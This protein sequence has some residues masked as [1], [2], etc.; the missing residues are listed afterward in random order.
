MNKEF[1]NILSLLA[2]ALTFTLL[3]CS[4]SDDFVQTTTNISEADQIAGD[5]N[6]ITMPLVVPDDSWR[7]N[8]MPV[9]KSS[10]NYDYRTGQAAFSWTI[11]DE[12]IVFPVKYVEND[13]VKTHEAESS[14]SQVWEIKAVKQSGTQSIGVFEGED[15]AV[16][17]HFNESYIAVYPNIRYDR[18]YTNIPITYEGQKQKES[19][20]IKCYLDGIGY[21]TTPDA[22]RL[23]QYV[24]SE[25]A[26]C[27]NLSKFD[28]LVDKE[29]AATDV[30][31]MM[32]FNMTRLGSVVRFFMKV[33]DKVVFDSLQLY[34]DSKNFVHTTTLNGATGEYAAIPTKESHVTSL[35]L[36]DFG[37]DYYKS[38]ENDDYY[39]GSG[40]GWVMTA[41]MMIAPIDL[42]A[43]ETKNST[44]YLIG[45]EPLYYT[46]VTDYN[47][48]H[49]GGVIDEAAFNALTAEQKIKLYTNRDDYNTDNNKNLT[50]EQFAALADDARMMV[51]ADVDAF[52]AAKGTS[53]T[54]EQ[55]AVLTPAQ[56]M[57]RYTRKY[58]KATNLAKYNITAGGLYQWTIVGLNPDQPI[59]F[60]EI[61]IQE[62]KEG[63]NYTNTDGAGT[64]DW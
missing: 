24:V 29:R 4:D 48:D 27:E 31:G 49:S 42:S 56:K 32:H 26:A 13:E 35:Q 47:N 12:V 14:T 43:A 11:G 46:N 51:Y 57:T 5:K 21:N 18:N 3:S 45:R 1:R 38:A 63:V 33:P 39:Y 60:E 44:L 64:G 53:L 52:N 54:A 9:P 19:P 20:K 37:F 16:T 15:E 62:W 28:Y 40:I 10:L 55:F 17:A 50:A 2:L 22:N 59:T 30:A 61:T 25:E 36:G 23:E 6:Y 34:N 41:Y 58:Y 7:G 8:E